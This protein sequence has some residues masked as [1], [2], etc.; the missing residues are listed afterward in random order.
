MANPRQRRKQR[1]TKSKLTR[2]TADRLKKV[3][4][5]GSAVIARHWDKTKTLAQNYAALGLVSDPNARPSSK[6]VAKP[7]DVDDGEGEREQGVVGEVDENGLHE[8]EAIIQRDASGNVVGIVY[9]KLDITQ[10]PQPTTSGAYLSDSESDDGAVASTTTLQSRRKRRGQKLATSD[11]IV[12]LEAAAAAAEEAEQVGKV[13]HVSQGESR[14]L[15]SI[16]AKYGDDYKRAAR[17]RRLNPMQQTPADIRA[18]VLKAR[19][20]QRPVVDSQAD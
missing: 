11:A 18:R 2:R 5:V 14:W 7:I 1:S 9:S 19:R 16:V 6:P 12:E 15:E 8:N 13:R 17:D 3:N 20:L 10:Q 4:V